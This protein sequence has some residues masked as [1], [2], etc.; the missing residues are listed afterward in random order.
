[1][2]MSSDLGNDVI[3]PSDSISQ[4]SENEG[5][6]FYYRLYNFLLSFLLMKF[7]FLGSDASGLFDK[8][9]K[10]RSSLYLDTGK[11]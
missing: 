4:L 5:I 10:R 2:S 8:R 6:I 9:Q 7:K 1:M 3:Y 11:L